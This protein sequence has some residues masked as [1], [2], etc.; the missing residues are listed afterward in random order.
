MVER[1]RPLRFSRA[2]VRG[3]NVS[4]T[5]SVNDRV[6][7][8]WAEGKNVYHLAFGES[9]FPVHHKVAD[10]L[11]ANVQRRSY[12]PPLG[13]PELRQ[14][15]ADWYGHTFAM[16]VA[17]SQ[18]VIGPGSK[19]LIYLALLTLGEEII[20]P[21]PSWVTYG[22]QAHLLGKPVTWIPTR[23]EDSFKIRHD[24]LRGKLQESHHD[25]GNPEVLVV[26]SPTNPT[27]TMMTPRE[28]EEL[29]RFAQSQELMVVSDEIYALMTFGETAHEPF[30]R[31]YPEGTLTMGGLSKSL[32]LGG[33][34]FGI[35]ILPAGKGGTALADAMRTIASNIWSCVTAP[36]Q[37]AAM[38][39][40]S[41]DPEVEGYIR[42][43]AAMHAVRTRYLYRTLVELG[44][45][46]AEPAGAFYIFPCFERWRQPLAARGVH[47]CEEL[48]LYLLDNYEIATLPGHAFNSAEDLCLRVSS[49][50]TDADSDEA[51]AAL[52]R[53]YRQDPDP[54]RFIRDHH[55]RMQK[56]AE[57]FGE[58]IA[59]LENG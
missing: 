27:G 43:C 56:V 52:V 9:R 59:D 32:S 25:L 47:D 50:Y 28:V 35:G 22:P 41:G 1:Y 46:C 30:A 40:Y 18:V 36:V 12:L 29:A 19:S 4:A 48:A 55:P 57:R 58:F 16:D 7:E 2:G 10:A 51:G 34:R 11:I 15:I 13:I 5:I 23:L 8:M 3:L 54:D 6:K 21:Q 44:V 39:A 42:L 14:T 33:W 31:H 26:N 17:P 49:S 38:V 53:A 37:Y 24:V 20:I 45:P